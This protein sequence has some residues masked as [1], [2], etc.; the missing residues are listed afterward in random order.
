MF[1]WT[2]IVL[3]FTVVESEVARCI[4]SY[5]HIYVRYYL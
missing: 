5:T 3:N 4:L 1:P 2:M